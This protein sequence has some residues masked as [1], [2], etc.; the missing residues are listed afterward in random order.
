M[1]PTPP[2]QTIRTTAG[3]ATAELQRRG[4]QSSDMVTITT[5]PAVSLLATARAAS[6]A[7]VMAAGLSDDDI[8]ELIRRARA[9]VAAEDE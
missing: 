2:N 9:E 8:D 6:R 7:R 1:Q 5:D 3:D 4:L